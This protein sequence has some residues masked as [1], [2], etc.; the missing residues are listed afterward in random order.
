M[1]AG[2]DDDGDLIIIHS[3]QDECDIDGATVLIIPFTL[4]LY[5]EEGFEILRQW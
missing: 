1:Y 3:S 2:C 4:P 5:I